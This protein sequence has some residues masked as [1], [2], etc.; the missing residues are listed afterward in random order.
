MYVCVIQNGDISL[1]K[2]AAVNTAVIIIIMVISKCY[3]SREHIAPSLKNGLS[4]ELG[5]NQQIKCTVHDAR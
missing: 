2:M 3:F 5:K 4:I 1:K